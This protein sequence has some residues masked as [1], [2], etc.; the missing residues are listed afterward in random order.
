VDNLQALGVALRGQ[1]R[2]RQFNLDHVAQALNMSIST[3]SRIESGV[4]GPTI[5]EL[6]AFA[7]FYKLPVGAF[8]AVENGEPIARLLELAAGMSEREQQ[9]LVRVAERL[10]DEASSGPAAGTAAVA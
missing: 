10:R 9:K 2:E 4:R 6:F 5:E 3:I 8:L 1:R 7:S